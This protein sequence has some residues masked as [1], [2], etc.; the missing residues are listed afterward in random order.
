MRKLN[1][2]GKNGSVSKKEM[3]ERMKVLDIGCGHSKSRSENS[4]GVVVGLDFAK[5]PNVDVVWNL[6]KTPLPFKDNEFNK[7][8]AHHVLEH[9]QNFVPLMNELWRVTKDE[10]EIN[11]KVPFYS[12]WGQFNDPTH[13]RF[14]TPFTFNYFCGGGVYSHEV[15][16]KSKMN[17]K[18]R[19]VN[20]QFGVGKTKILNKIINP[21]LNL[22]HAIYCRFF[23]WIF[24]AA[25]LEFRLEVV[26]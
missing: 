26:K 6:E 2:G 1:I 15:K 9:I 20:I 22:N 17:F 4:Y 3:K 23:A 11:I 18:L 7:I 19:K 8:I 25:E 5:L 12:S 21:L 10:G 14:F 13:V 16:N 24:P